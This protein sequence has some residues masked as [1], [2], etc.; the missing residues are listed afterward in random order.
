MRGYWPQHILRELLVLA[1]KTGEAR[2][3]CDS[4]REAE[5][6]RKALYNFRTGAEVG[7]GVTITV[8]AN[9][10]VLKATERPHVEIID[11]P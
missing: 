5:L 4:P 2:A 10:V 8:D 11:A 6:M 9:I 1:E 7:L 3:A